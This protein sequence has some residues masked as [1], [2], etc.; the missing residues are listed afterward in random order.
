[1]NGSLLHARFFTAAL[2]VLS[3]LT[4]VGCAPQRAVIRAT[5]ALPE[6][7]P[8][9]TSA[10][11]G[12]FRKV[13]VMAGRC[14][15]SPESAQSGE[16]RQVEEIFGL[17]CG[18]QYALI[19]AALTHAGLQVVSWRQVK[20][21][22]EANQ[23]T[24]DEAALAL[25][26]DSVLEINSLETVSHKLRDLMVHQS[27]VMLH[28]G[29]PAPERPLPADKDGSLAR[30]TSEHLA[31]I[32]ST[33]S[34][35]GNPLQGRACGAAINVKLVG[36]KNHIAQWFFRSHRYAPLPTGETIVE[37]RGGTWVTVVPSSIELAPCDRHRYEKM[38]HEVADEM[39]QRLVGR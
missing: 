25:N 10:P 13:A 15:D 36:T 38:V 5:F 6:R 8:G 14:K 17:T 2:F 31:A 3:A 24:Y 1:M 4:S 39:A 23:L 19:E 26:A 21:F 33:I 27:T 29:V 11:Q 32:A 22:S 28:Q 12:S 35:T 18:V 37:R 16:D 7:D 20:E 9:R 34:R 30:L